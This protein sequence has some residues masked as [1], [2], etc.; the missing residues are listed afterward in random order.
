MKD[1]IGHGVKKGYK[2]SI[3]GTRLNFSDKGCSISL[4]HFSLLQLNENCRYLSPG[5]PSVTCKFHLRRYF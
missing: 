2:V 4:F 3:T 1:L 5:C